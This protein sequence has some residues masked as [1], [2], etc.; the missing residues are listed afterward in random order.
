MRNP[1]SDK[2]KYSLTEAGEFVIGDYNSAKPFSSFFPGIAG[3]NGIPM[4]VFYVNRG[5]CIAG[6]GIQ[7]KDHAIL[8]FLPANRAYNLTSS[9]GFRTFIKLSGNSS[10]GYYEP[11]QNNYRDSHLNRTQRMIIAPSCLTLE[12]VNHSLNLK[13]TVDF[14]T[15]PLDKYAGLIRILRIHNSGDDTVSLEGLDGLPVIIP[16]GVDNFGL[17][18]MRRTIEAFVEVSNLENRVPF[19]RAKVEPADRPDVM[20]ISKGNFYLGFE[21]LGSGANIITPIVDPSRIFGRQTD[22]SYPERFFMFSPEEISKDQMLE[23]QLPCAMGIFTTSIPAGETY[24]YLS[25]IGHAPSLN[26]LN[27]MVSSIASHEYIESKADENRE[28][29]ERLTQN[30]LICSNEPALDHYVRQNF[31]DNSMRGGFPFTLTSSKNNET[32]YLY[33]RKH[34]DMERDY[35]DFSLMPTPYSQGNGNFRDINQNRRSDLL[36]NPDLGKQNVEYFYNLIQLDGFNPLVLKEIYFTAD[37]L[38]KLQTVLKKYIQAEHLQTVNSFI[39]ESFTPGELLAFFNENDITLNVDSEIFLGEILDHCRRISNTDYGESY[40]IDHWTYNLDLLENYL[41]VYPDKFPNLLFEEKI[42]SFYDN[43]HIVQRRDEKY[44][45]WNDKAMQLGAVMFDEEKAKSIEKRKS[46]RNKIRTEHG[47]G[48]VYYTTLFSKILCLIVNKLA[49]L[50]PEGVGV[51]MEAGK[52]G[53]YDALN[54][55]PG[56][57][58][59]SISE[60]LEI[61]RNI[62]FLL[63]KISEYK[64]SDVKVVLFDEL[65]EFMHELHVLLDRRISPYEF[66]DAAS[67][68]KERYREMTR[69]GISGREVTVELNEIT[70]FF[71][72]ALG[73][74]NEGIAKSHEKESNTIFTYFRYE[75]TDYE[76]IEITDSSGEKKL[77]CNAGGHSCIRPLKFKK[78]PLPLFLEGPVHYLRCHPEKEEASKFVANVKKSG[79]YDKPLKMYKVNTSLADEPMEIGR[80]RVF[81]PG[82]LENESIWLHMEYKYMLELLRNGLYEDFYRDFKNLFIP[83]LDPAVYG[84]SILENSSFIAS[85]AHPDPS[86]HGNGFVARLSGATAEFIHIL[87]LLASGPRPFRLDAKGKL[88]LCLTPS[89]PGWLFTHEERKIRVF[90]ENQCQEVDLPARTFSFMFLGKILVTYHNIDLKDTYGKAGVTPVEWKIVDLDGN[91]QTFNTETLSGEIVNKIRERKV[92]RIEIVLR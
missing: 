2:S 5:Q 50:D 83:F 68:A 53:W 77:K 88:Q 65:K 84:R 52:P 22:F 4:W 18:N 9:H 92:N 72:A 59:S 89:L 26:K 19:F 30:N 90:Q 28:L 78:I 11:F 62:L 39:D 74:L 7:D 86:I 25:I 1:E 49:S 42:F 54:G 67:A 71:E 91:I 37:D 47:K 63:E 69:R 56:L 75:V 44:V 46:E 33:S 12:E 35:N 29:I 55:L 81:S 36:F 10:A 13:F 14:F 20:R 79:L 66:W 8:E 16:Y 6:M 3:I 64:A 15:V 73:K 41:A 43:P 85:S 23:N 34:G 76:E 27:E 57:F 51:E 58:G 17:K 80:A 48:H 60:T 82:W 40:W 31:L 32:L 45:L 38:D 87:L 70:D 21:T 24:T 61:K